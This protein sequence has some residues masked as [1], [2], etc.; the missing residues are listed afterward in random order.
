MIVEFSK[1]NY[2]GKKVWKLPFQD[3]Y[4]HLYLKKIGY[5]FQLSSD[6]ESFSG[7]NFGWNLANERWIYIYYDPTFNQP[8][9]YSFVRKRGYETQELP[10]IDIDIAVD[11]YNM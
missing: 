3:K 11:K 10:K 4:L 7:S 9:R 6:N 1:Y 8:W 5:P 2:S